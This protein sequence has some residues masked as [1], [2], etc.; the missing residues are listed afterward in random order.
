[1]QVILTRPRSDSEPL[2]EILRA[3]GDCVHVEPMLEIA[4]TGD[5]VSLDGVQAILATSA[6]GVRCL[7]DTTDIRD[8]PIYTVGDATAHRAKELGYTAI[9]SAQGDSGA[10]ASLVASRLDPAAG[11]LLHVRGRDST[12][13]FSEKLESYGF[14]VRSAI[15]YR[16]EPAT[17]LSEAFKERLIAEKSAFILFFSPRTARTFVSLVTGAGLRDNCERMSAIC[18][19]RAVADAASAVRW[20]E[21]HIATAPDQTAMIQEYDALKIARKDTQ[22]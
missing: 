8:L 4:P 2:A 19:S 22:L 13:G 5:S 9:E 11:D 21:V 7:A 12:E 10:L 16:A 14:R 18:L 3:R 20:G 1:V 6:N 17:E 15:L